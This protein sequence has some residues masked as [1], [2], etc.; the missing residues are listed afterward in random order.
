MGTAVIYPMAL[1]RVADYLQ[2]DRQRAPAVLLQLRKPQSPVSVREWQKHRAVQDIAPAIDPR[3]KMVT[4][5][6]TL[7]LSLY[8]QVRELLEGLQSEMDHSTAVLDEVYGT[9]TELK[10][11]QL[12]LSTRRIYSNLRSPAYRN[13]LPYVPNQTGFT[14]DPHVLTLLVEPLYGKH[15][16]VG[17]R[18]LI[19]NSA[20]AVCE[21]RAWCEARRLAVQSLDLPIL[22]G[23]VLVD[24]VKRNDDSW[25]LQVRDRGIGMSAETI[26]NY[27]LR[28]GAS[29]RRSSEWAK[30]F[31]DEQGQPRVLRTGRFG[32]GAFAVFLLGPSFKLWTRHAGADRSMGYMIE[33]SANSQLIE[34][35]RVDGLQIG[36]TIEVTISDESAASLG[37]DKENYTGYDSIEPKIDWFCWSWPKIVKSV[38]R[39][40]KRREL[41]A[42]NK[43]P[44]RVKKTP[45][46]WFVIHPQG[47]DA[48]YW[49]FGDGP[50][51]SCN[52]LRLADPAYSLTDAYFEWPEASQLRAPVLAVV[53]SAANLPV[54][55][56]RYGLSGTLPFLDDLVRD[57]TVS[58]IA[59]A[60]VC[61]PTS[62]VDAVSLL[63]TH[64]LVSGQYSVHDIRDIGE[65]G[66]LFSRGDLRWCAT[67]SETVPADSW[68]CS[69]LQVQSYAVCGE[70]VFQRYARSDIEKL[71]LDQ[72]V[73]ADCAVIPWHILVDER[74]FSR[75]RGERLPAELLWR[76]AN[77]GVK[78]LGLEPEASRVL[79]ST[80]DRFVFS[81][82][83]EDIWRQ[84]TVP[85]SRGNRFET[86]VGTIHSP[87]SL[88][89]LIDD[90][91]TWS[92]MGDRRYYDPY[93]KVVYAAEIRAKPEKRTPETLIAKLWNE[94][95]GP[96]AIPFDA[97]AREGLIAHG[98]KHPEL[99]R[100]I[101]AWKKMKRAGSKWVLSGRDNAA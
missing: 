91:E 45:P 81:S 33:A 30:E 73:L 5:S 21:L 92:A 4:V 29:F 79:V 15:P 14:A 64:P 95:L 11:N 78:A 100:H 6:T 98:S 69:L 19:Q 31:L 43:I 87:I 2:I 76:L 68:L 27:F 37:L 51:L 86:T 84:V 18:E 36:T 66:R 9:L 13:S 99:K 90:L 26:Q 89:A 17:V 52:G 74:E 55:T 101:D 12:S 28:A 10:L 38:C 85:V 77:E 34:I 24:F 39:G 40:T 60:L 48:V 88:T 47:F 61:G 7:G 72:T 59:H 94:C 22:D 70:I 62:R 58:F 67:A 80:T 44:I 41:R 63:Y 49:S 75:G 54:T 32:I 57:V 8:L 42:E 35:K 1:L 56:Q 82:G 20:D 50:R 97:A 16:S 25:F 65:V 46:D 53:D 96:K 23:D 83:D 71:R 93:S 3:G